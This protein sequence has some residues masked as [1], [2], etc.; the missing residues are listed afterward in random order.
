MRIGPGQRRREPRPQERF[1]GR[2]AGELHWHD[3]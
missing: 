1:N 3:I 2:K